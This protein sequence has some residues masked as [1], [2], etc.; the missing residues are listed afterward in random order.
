MRTAT[1]VACA[2]FVLCGCYR[3]AAPTNP[4]TTVRIDMVDT[5]TALVRAQLEVQR[6]LGIA[7]A[8]RLGWTVTPNGTARLAVSLSQ[9][10]IS[11]T[12]GDRDGIAAR[13]RITLNGSFVFEHGEQRHVA[14]F[15][16]I[17]HASSLSDEPAAIR[18]AAEDAAA[19]I[20]YHL[21]LGDTAGGRGE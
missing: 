10:D 17:G 1:L 4:G 16:G 12:A 11:V 19:V 2:L 18:K 21:E 5:D 8:Q 13:W 14:T 7:L 20:T 3:I 15:T 9:E 6:A